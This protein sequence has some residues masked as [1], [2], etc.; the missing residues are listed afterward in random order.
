[1]SGIVQ[2][3]IQ[4][5]VGIITM[6]R[7]D[8]RNALSRQMVTELIQAFDLLDGNDQVKVILLKGEGKSFCAGGDLDTMQNINHS[9]DAVKWVDHVANL[10]QKILDLDKYVV[11]MVHGYGAGAGFSL[12]LAC[13]FV[14]MED[15]AKFVLSFNHVGLIPDLGL[16]RL[17]YERIPPVIFK[18]WIS[19]GKIIDAQEAL[20]YGLINRVA[21]T[22]ITDET[23]DFIQFMINGPTIA[24][25][26]VKYLANHMSDL[27][28]HASF[29]KENMIQSILLQTEDHKEGVRAFKEKRDPIF[30]GR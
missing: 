17:L 1:M 22:N 30:K 24:N 2:V 27:P 5:A 4:N 3:D 11:A 19:S 8:K 25:K 20:R 21:K 29:R 9:Y 13:D 12:A 14:V 15:Q 10:T 16:I 18:E 6:N 26:Y 28:L 7:P 23:M